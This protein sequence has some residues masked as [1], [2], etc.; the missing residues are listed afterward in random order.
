LIDEVFQVTNEQAID[1]ARAIMRL[2]GLL[3]GISGGAAAYAAIQ[4]GKRPENAGKNIVVIMP[5]TGER[6]LSTILFAD[7]REQ[8][9]LP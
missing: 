9:Q 2:E 8:L 5:D 1:T 7:I 4:V 6:Y 3:V